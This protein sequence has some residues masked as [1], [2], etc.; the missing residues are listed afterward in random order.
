MKPSIFVA[1]AMAVA[2]SLAL[3]QFA[4]SAQKTNGSIKGW[5]PAGPGDGKHTSFLICRTRLIM[6]T[7]RGPCPGL[8]TLAN[9]HYLP[10]DGRD[11]TLQ[12]LGDAM[13][14][15][16][17]VNRGDAR[18]LFTQ[19]ARTNPRYPFERDSFDL[20]TL[21]REGVLEHDI[22]LRYASSA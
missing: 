3:P 10:H 13:L 11:I 7:A 8:N 21:G 20:D 18:L 14:E 1:T 5:E 19:A 6:W 2:P 15:G 12:K 4:G 16:F 17:N 22:S 9:H